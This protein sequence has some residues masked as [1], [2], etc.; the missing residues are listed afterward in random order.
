MFYSSENQKNP[1][2][3]NNIV[4]LSGILDS[5]WSFSYSTLQGT[6]YTA[7]LAVKRLSGKVDHLTLT[8]SDHL[9]NMNLSYKGKAIAVSGQIRSHNLNEGTKRKVTLTIF[10]K[11]LTLLQ[12]LSSQTNE[13][14]IRL[15][16]FLCRH[17]LYRQTPK[18]RDL[19]ELLLAIHRKDGR[20]D[21]IPCICWG[22]CAHTAAHLETGDHLLLWGRIQSRDYQKRFPNGSLQ[23]LTT[24][25][26]S[27]FRINTKDFTKQLEQ[28]I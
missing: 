23:V 12:N 27:T 16:G 4:Y 10:I 20:S 2:L 9:L 14:R 19:T 28:S 22:R 17:P 21:Y 3:E 24:Y 15:N 6:F 5:E 7:N 13:N 18:G 26:V 8:I 1:S 25:E 11:E